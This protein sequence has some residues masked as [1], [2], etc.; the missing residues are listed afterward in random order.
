MRTDNPK[1]IIPL[2]RK[3]YP[4]MIAEQI[5]GVQP[6]TS[7]STQVFNMKVTSPYTVWTKWHKTVSIWPRKSISG[8]IIFGYINKRGRTYNGPH[9]NLRCR[10]FATDKEVFTSRLKGDA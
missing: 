3:V 4:K 8:N 5:V 9:G 1:I 10:E 6:M 2:I 7:S